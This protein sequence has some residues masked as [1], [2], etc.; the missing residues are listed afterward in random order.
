MGSGEVIVS[1]AMPGMAHLCAFAL[2]Q[3]LATLH[4][5]A[6][7]LLGM[8]CPRISSNNAAIKTQIS[9][10]LVPGFNMVFAQRC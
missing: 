6:F 1:G 7:L 4:C 5:Q 3:Q 9:A 8:D 10:P 2:W